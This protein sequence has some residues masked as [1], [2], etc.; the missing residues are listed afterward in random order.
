MLSFVWI[1]CAL[2]HLAPVV[3]VAR[4]PGGLAPLKQPPFT[5]TDS[6]AAGLAPA[7]APVAYFFDQ[8]LDHSNPSLGTFPQRFWFYDGYYKD[9]GPVVL[10][11]ACV[12]LQ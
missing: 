9:G 6:K 11:N 2:V 7:P 10:F 3:V 5:F 1:A 12:R 8:I 4:P